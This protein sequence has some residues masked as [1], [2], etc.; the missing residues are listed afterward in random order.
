MSRRRLTQTEVTDKYQDLKE[1]LDELKEKRANTNSDEEKNFYTKKI[2]AAKKNLNNFKRQYLDRLSPQIKKQEQL[3]TKPI[4][5]KPT[6]LKAKLQEIREKAKQLLEQA[7]TEE[8][9][10]SIKDRLQAVELRYKYSY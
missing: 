7:T 5:H 6:T 8:E 10:Q 9:K 1:I 4:I 2:S 3:P